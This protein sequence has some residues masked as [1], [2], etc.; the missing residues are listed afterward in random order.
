MVYYPESDNIKEIFPEGIF[1]RMLR[2][3]DS[4]DKR[5]KLEEEIQKC[6]GQNNLLS[7]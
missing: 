3:Q 2:D 5:R 4:E 6:L 7:G 1:Q